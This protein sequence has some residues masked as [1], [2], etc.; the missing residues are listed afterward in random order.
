MNYNFIFIFE[1][2]NNSFSGEKYLNLLKIIK[3]EIIVKV[4]TKKIKISLT[5]RN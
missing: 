2:E 3:I 4:F 1:E 5:Y